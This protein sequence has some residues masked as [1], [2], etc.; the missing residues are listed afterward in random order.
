MSTTATAR[1]A[2]RILFDLGPIIA[3]AAAFNRLNRTEV[4]RV[5]KTGIPAKPRGRWEAFLAEKGA[6]VRELTS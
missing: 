6:K 4:K 3:F 2:G 1:G 5:F